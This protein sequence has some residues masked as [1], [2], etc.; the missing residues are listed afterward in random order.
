[1]ERITETTEDLHAPGWDTS[2]RVS[3]KP[4][5]GQPTYNLLDETRSIERAGV[6][7]KMPHG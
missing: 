6:F 1:M 3:R 2:S 5:T 4:K 7:V